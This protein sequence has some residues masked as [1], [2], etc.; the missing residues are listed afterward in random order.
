LAVTKQITAL[1]CLSKIKWLEPNLKFIDHL[2]M[3]R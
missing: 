1:L 2:Q 3:L